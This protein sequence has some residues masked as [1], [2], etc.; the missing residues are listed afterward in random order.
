MLG[1]LPELSQRI[2]QIA[3]DHG[4]VTIRAAAE[5]TGASRNTIKDGVMAA[6][7]DPVGSSQPLGQ[8]V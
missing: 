3:R 6:G 7:P 1:D 2:L 8:P 5:A 4:R